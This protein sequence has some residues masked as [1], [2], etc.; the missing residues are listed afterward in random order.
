MTFKNNEQLRF[1]L[2]RSSQLSDLE[3]AYK[4]LDLYYQFSR[5]MKKPIDTEKLIEEKL[6]VAEEINNILRQKKTRF[7]KHC[8]FCNKP[9]PYNHQ[10][11]LCDSCYGNF[12]YLCA[13]AC[14]KILAEGIAG[15]VLLVTPY[16]NAVSEEHRL[17]DAVIYPPLEQVP[18][19][20]A[21]SKRNQWMIRQAD[22]V[23]A[24]V[25]ASVGGAYKTLSFARKKKKN[26][27]NLAE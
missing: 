20:Y 22:L 23:I 3:D 1:P 21:I 14:R 2:R 6:R 25:S 17:Y 10:Y 24:Y 11:G 5:R 19:R 16:L 26:V 4:C 18:P 13:R 27:I 8:R 7:Q 12:D 9:L 15:E